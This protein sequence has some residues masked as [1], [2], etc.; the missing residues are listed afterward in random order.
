MCHTA[1]VNFVQA[2]W[3]RAG[4]NEPINRIVMHDAE[5][6]EKMTG[7]EDIAAYFARGT[8]KASAHYAV[9]VDSIVQCVHDYDTAFHAPP[10][11]YSIGIELMGYAKQVFEEWLDNY[12]IKMLRDQAAPLVRGLCLKHSVPMRWLNVDDL[13]AGRR[14]ITS[15]W[16]VSLAFGQSTHTD[17]GGGFPVTQFMDWVTGAAPPEPTPPTPDPPIEDDYPMEFF[18]LKVQDDSGQY[19]WFQDAAG[20]RGYKAIQ[21]DTDDVAEARKSRHYLGDVVLMPPNVANIPDL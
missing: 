3:Y 20:G 16:N 15:H 18:V 12:G 9:D 1:R 17:P 19:L 14:G 7:A 8:K 2:K 11:Q 5:Y 13:K 4:G 10:N 6:P 21:H